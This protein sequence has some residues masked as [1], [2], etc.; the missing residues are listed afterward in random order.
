[1]GQWLSVKVRLDAEAFTQLG[2]FLGTKVPCKS[3]LGVAFECLTYCGC[4]IRC[5][6]QAQKKFIYKHL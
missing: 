1:M 2:K 3:G 6:I 4:L 5:Q